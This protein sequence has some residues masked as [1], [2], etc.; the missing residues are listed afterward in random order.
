MIR[1]KQIA[2]PAMAIALSACLAACNG[3]AGQ[4]QAADGGARE[5][6]AAQTTGAVPGEKDSIKI[7]D[8]DWSVDESLVN[9]DRKLA[10]SYTNN[11][12]FTIIRF[13]VEYVQREDV[14]DEER[15]AFDEAYAN[16][17][18]LPTEEADKLYISGDNHH[19]VEPG[20]TADA[21]SCSLAYAFTAP[22]VDQL[23]LM[24]PSIATIQ[25][26]GGDGNIYVEHYDFINDDYELN[27]SA[28]EAVASAWPDAEL[29]QMVPGLEAPVLV[30]AQ[31][32]E[33]WFECRGYGV[34]EDAFSSYVDEC[35]EFGF[36]TVDYDGDTW[37]V[38]SNKDGYEVDVTYYGDSDSLDVEV[39]AP[40]E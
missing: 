23:A 24:E 12:P 6:E 16:P 40:E 14:T 32:E 15:S 33:D 38:A 34:G 30:V 37:F 9:G 22:T 35:R 39:T 29:A 7:E 10:L 18:W 5:S 27:D 26:V 11:S 21:V 13:R 25:Y 31:D 20:Q 17:D 3:N 4:G 1:L 19:F 2:I 8:L 28:T 36:D